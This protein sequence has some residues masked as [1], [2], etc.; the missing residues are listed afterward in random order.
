MPA[1]SAAE[2]WRDTPLPEEFVRSHAP[3]IET[4]D[5]PLCPVCGEDRF[6]RFAVGF[7]YELLTCRNPWRFVRCA[8]CGHVWLH[9]RPA[10]ATL[11]TIYPPTYYAYNYE[12][13]IHSI[14]VRAKRW[15]DRGKMR[16]ILRHLSAPPRTF[17]DIGCGDGRFLKVMEGH[18]VERGNNYGLEL[19]EKV[20]QKLAGEGYQAFCQRVEEC[21]RIPANRIDLATMFHVIE[22]VDAPAA[23]ARKVAGWLAPDGIFAVETPNLESLDARWFG[24]TFW[25]G[26]HIPRHWSLFTPASLARML[27]DAGLEVIATRYQ[28]GHSFWMYSVHHWLRYGETPRPGLARW[29]DPFKGLPMLAMFTVFDKLRAAVG[30]RTSSILM[31]ARKPRG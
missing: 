2:S 26:Y 29:F 5:V 24:R 7:D 18:G 13:H 4:E 16:G 23:V 15:L 9:P 1:A 14:A 31:L 19:G 10:V 11:G 12:Q 30:C 25:G 6:A 21:E 28:T 20:V 27:K 22:H 8:G 3:L 17:L